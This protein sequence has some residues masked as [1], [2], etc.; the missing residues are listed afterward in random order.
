[1]ISR[2]ARVEGDVGG[3]AAVRDLFAFRRD[4]RFE[5]VSDS[6]VARWVGS[7]QAQ[8]DQVLAGKAT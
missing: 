6:S 7:D 2:I 4:G 8:V 5:A 3:R 1:V